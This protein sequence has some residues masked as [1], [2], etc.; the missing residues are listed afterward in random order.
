MKIFLHG[1]ELLKSQGIAK[2]EGVEKMTGPIVGKLAQEDLEE[3]LG[4]YLVNFILASVSNAHK[5]PSD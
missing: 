5:N 4:A 3:M 2:I 1:A